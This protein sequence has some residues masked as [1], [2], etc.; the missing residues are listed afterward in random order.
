M[1]LIF[2]LYNWVR[3]RTRLPKHAQI[4]R[5]KS[6]DLY[7][8]ARAHKSFG[9]SNACYYR[10]DELI[11][12]ATL[13]LPEDFLDYRWFL[14][15]FGGLVVESSREAQM[16]DPATLVGRIAQGAETLRCDGR[17]VYVLSK[18]GNDHYTWRRVQ[19]SNHVL[20]APQFPIA[21]PDAKLAV[22]RCGLLDG[23][24]WIPKTIK[25]GSI[26]W[27]DA[28]K[29]S[30]NTNV[31]RLYLS[32]GGEGG[33]AAVPTQRPCA[34]QPGQTF[35]VQ[36]EFD[37]SAEL[38]ASVYVIQYTPSGRLKHTSYNPIKRPF[39]MITLDPKAV[40]IR[41]A[42]RWSGK[43]DGIVRRFDILSPAP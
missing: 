16:V 26:D 1:L 27:T 21:N 4:E 35:A 40:A 8:R 28:L 29:I 2:N 11:G 6:N 41:F 36:A 13:D 34:V 32:T 42:I 17:N 31:K 23:A 38:S 30:I 19:G 33:F 22:Q 10:I 43:G 14:E 24:Q 39:T 3:N 12:G 15:R 18:P 20:I 37:L 7:T 5:A 25:T 9:N